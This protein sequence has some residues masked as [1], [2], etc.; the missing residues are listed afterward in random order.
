MVK[1]ISIHSLLPPHTVTRISSYKFRRI[2]NYENH[3]LAFASWHPNWHP[4]IH[5]IDTKNQATR[6]IC[7]N[8]REFI[9]LSFTN[10]FASDCMRALLFHIKAP[11]QICQSR[12][13]LEQYNFPFLPCYVTAWRSGPLYIYCEQFAIYFTNAR[14][15]RTKHE[16]V[17]L[18]SFKQ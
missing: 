12:M 7:W 13:L 16:D 11:R 1:F 17:H 14:T 8:E 18:N 6:I 2:I 15:P 5:N 9:I 4:L 10:E 3:Y